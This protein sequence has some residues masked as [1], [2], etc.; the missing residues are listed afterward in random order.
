MA[1]YL[2]LAILPVKTL[3]RRVSSRT[4]RR[5][6]AGDQ[7]Q[8]LAAQIARDGLAGFK[9]VLKAAGG[10]LARPFAAGVDRP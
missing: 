1:N 2:Y 10:G 6:E 5:A 9:V 8:G 7:G 4:P 3:F